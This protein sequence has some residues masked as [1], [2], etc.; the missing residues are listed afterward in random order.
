MLSSGV[1]TTGGGSLL[2]S[3]TTAHASS[4]PL[5]TPPRRLHASLSADI[6]LTVLTAGASL[7]PEDLCTRN[8]GGRVLNCTPSDGASRCKS[9]GSIAAAAA[10]SADVSPRQRRGGTSFA[11]SIIAD[12]DSPCGSPRI[13]HARPFSSFNSF[14]KPTLCGS[15][16]SSVAPSCKLADGALANRSPSG[17]HGVSPCFSMTT[18]EAEEDPAL[19][20]AE[21]VFITVPAECGVPL[22]CIALAANDARPP[23]SPSF[24]YFPGCGSGGGALHESASLT[25]NKAS[26]VGARPS[27][28]FNSVQCI[29]EGWAANAS[30]SSSTESKVFE[31]LRFD[32]SDH[33]FSPLQ[34][35]PALDNSQ[36]ASWVP[37]LEPRALDGV[38][39]SA[40]HHDRPLA[41]PLSYEYQEK[42]SEI[43]KRQ[44][45]LH[46]CL[47]SIVRER[48]EEP[49]AHQSQRPALAKVP[50]LRHLR[51]SRLLSIM[52]LLCTVFLRLPLHIMSRVLAMS[53]G[54]L[55]KV[56]LQP[57]LS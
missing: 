26:A 30:S 33:L 47:V 20:G 9:N 23:S 27:L 8:A 55:R 45:L 19:P 35:T 57:R 38:A 12:S 32:A 21:S 36:H 52:W 28:R 6:E 40:H 42:L 51:V 3:G 7:A 24:T 11:S 18:S 31:P 48:N 13:R 56:L 17:L 2:C 37:A 15:S 16:R 10:L 5:E 46:A 25:S 44:Q 29:R 43:V 54:E 50:K 14:P 34:R 4:I 22:R 53:A 49:G 41:C 39:A 1:A